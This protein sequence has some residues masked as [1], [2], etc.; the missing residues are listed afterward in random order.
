MH[1]RRLTGYEKKQDSIVL[2]QFTEDLDKTVKEDKIHVE[3]YPS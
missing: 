2:E 1:P 3:F